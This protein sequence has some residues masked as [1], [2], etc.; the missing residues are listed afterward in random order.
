LTKT[1]VELSETEVRTILHGAGGVFS[2][3]D[4]VSKVLGYLKD[5]GRHEAVAAKGGRVGVISLR[6]LLGVDHPGRTKVESIWKQ[7]GALS[8]G[9]VV[10]DA[11]AMLMDKGVRAL[12]VVE[13][14][15]VVGAVSQIDIIEALTEVSDLRNMAAKEHMQN[16][17]I[18]VEHGTGVAHARRMMLDKNISNIPVTREGRLVGMVT[19]DVIVHTFITPASKT[20]RGDVVGEKVT[21]FPGKV[22]DVMDPQ[23]FT[24][25]PDA[26]MLRVV[27]GMSKSGKTAC[28]M[29][30]DE[31]VVH[32]IVTPR[33]FLGLI[34]GLRVE[35]EIPVYIVG[36]TEE[37]FFER[38]VAEDKLRRIVAKN[39][40]IHEGITE[41]SVRIKKQSTQGERAR[42]RLN[43]R[44][45]GP[46]VSF[47]AEHEGWG[48]METFDGLCDALDNTLR[49]AKKEPQKGARRGRRH[50]RPH[51]K[52]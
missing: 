51:L 45:M 8:P 25:G 27:Q 20:T 32:G 52:P 47:N 29:V 42:Y 9:A 28:I 37:D 34:A 17:V 11:A 7:V 23:P 13:N 3:G 50:S 26:D 5:T 12:P 16:P 10:I 19:S 48:L 38:A 33:E 22:S 15:E 30:D 49:R 40:R 31:G 36:I 6:D 21:G 1:L 2:P 41:V 39:M 43:A 46:N 44:V 24:V 18:T 14:G 35:D 4:Q